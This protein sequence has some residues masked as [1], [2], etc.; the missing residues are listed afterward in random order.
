MDIDDNLN[1][2]KVLEE[3][4]RMRNILIIEDLKSLSVVD[5]SSGQKFYNATKDLKNTTKRWISWS[6]I[7]FERISLLC[8]C[9]QNTD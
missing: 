3:L 9:T 7:A 2:C 4:I 1:F 8:K 6:Y 5:R